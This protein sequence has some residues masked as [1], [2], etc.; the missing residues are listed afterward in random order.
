M[1]NYI[2][3]AFRK[4]DCLDED[5]FDVSK[6]GTEQLKDFIDDDIEGETVQIIDTEA[7]DN[8]DIEDSYIGKVILNCPVCHSMHY[9]DKESI[10]YDDESE[11]VDISKPCPYCHDVGGFEVIGEVAPYADVEVKVDDETVT[12]DGKEEEKEK[13]EVKVEESCGKKLKEAP[14]Y[15]LNTQFDSRKS[16]G[17][18]AQVD[19]QGDKETLYSY[20]T[21]VVTIEKGKVTLLPKWDLSA[22]TLRHVKEF[23]K[24]HGFKADSRN[25]IAADYAQ[26]MEE[27]LKESLSNDTK[28]TKYEDVLDRDKYKKHF[29]KIEDLLGPEELSGGYI[30]KIKNIVEENYITVYSDGIDVSHDFTFDA[31]VSGDFDETDD[32][33]KFINEKWIRFDTSDFR[34]EPYENTCWYEFDEGGAYDD[35]MQKDCYNARERFYL[36]KEFTQMLYD[37]G[38]EFI[39][40]DGE[41]LRDY[42]DEPDSDEGL[43]ESC[44]KSV[45]K[46][47]KKVKEDKTSDIDRIDAKRDDRVEK[48]RANLKKTID[49]ADAQRDDE[50]K[51]IKEG[52]SY[53]EIATIEDEWKKFKEK[54][55]RSDASAAMEFIETECKGVYDTDE[56]KDE[57]F[58]EISSLEE[59]DEDLGSWIASRK[60]KKLE[61][62]G[63]AGLSD[64]EKKNFDLKRKEYQARAQ[65]GAKKA[66]PNTGDKANW[67]QR[68]LDKANELKKKG[69]A[70]LGKETKKNN[71]IKRSREEL[72]KKFGIKDIDELKKLLAG[73]GVSL[74]EAL[75]MEDTKLTEAFEKV[76]LETATE[77][78]KVESEPKEEKTGDETIIPLKDETIKEIEANDETV[79]DS[80]ADIDEIDEEDV[81]ELGESYLKKVYENVNS[82]KSNNCKIE[83]GKLIIEGVIGFKSGKEKNT[84]FVFESVNTTKTGKVK[85]LGENKGISKCKNAFTFT[86]KVDNKKFIAES[87]T[88][89]Y[90]AKADS[91]DTAKK[92]YGR[93]TKK[94]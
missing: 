13:E 78:I 87:L 9:A 27:T 26:T 75:R 76:E 11:L 93:V 89:K 94:K 35:C 5:L 63:K 20:D 24:Q 15:G 60:L 21:P 71:Q 62:S 8:E 42:V 57:V 53:G 18:K 17:G 74:S 23:L 39:G 80:F 40:V 66:N 92:I 1:A 36:D 22:T 64:E 37:A 52:L 82:F 81:D 32:S 44:G 43:E 2:T 67:T 49:D 58:A 29:E 6:E 41:Y 86:G 73:A 4:L 7:E 12:D 55:G 83:N 70:D 45:K 50:K 34:G 47:F 31:L 68:N 38:N 90:N 88:Y 25:Q 3:E 91:D 14:I 54:T 48:A 79:E 61:K 56:E 72:F 33:G 69:S 85:I 51:E 10:E 28:T 65:R 16:F 19:V 59:L 77:K 46:S 30:K 84:S